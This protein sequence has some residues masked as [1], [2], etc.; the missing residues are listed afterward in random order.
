M[1]R[2]ARC[3]VTVGLLA[4]SAAWV[5]AGH[6]R[7]PEIEE[8]LYGLRGK[9]F[10]LKVDVVRVQRLLGGQDATNVYPDGRVSYRALL[11]GLRSTV[12]TNAKDFVAEVQRISLQQKDENMTAR[13]WNRGTRMMIHDT[14]AK[15]DETQIDITDPGGS[16]TRIRFK[17][18][19]GPY[20]LHDVKKAFDVAFAKSE[21]E[22]AGAQSTVS[23]HL[24]MSV[25]G[26]IA[27]KGKPKTRVD[28]GR[29]TILTYDDMKLVF[30]DDKLA[31]VQ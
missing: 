25:E 28:L 26:V 22:L 2:V 29:K 5:R 27:K 20:S 13:V 30:E 14:E 17:F 9:S 3:L 21:A 1:R 10:F 18:E 4:S 19:D 23:L 31:D 11:T 12:T 15:D 16:K 7:S 8:Y 24:G 6:Q